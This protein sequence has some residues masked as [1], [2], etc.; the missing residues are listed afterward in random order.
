MW[1]KPSP[2]QADSCL[3]RSLGRHPS[4]P[5]EYTR[6]WQSCFKLRL[7]DTALDSNLSDRGRTSGVWIRGM[8]F[9]FPRTD[10]VN[11]KLSSLWK[12]KVWKGACSKSRCWRGYTTIV[13]CRLPLILLISG[14]LASGGRTPDLVSI[15]IRLYFLCIYV[16]LDLCMV[17]SPL[18]SPSLPPSPFLLILPICL[19]VILDF[20]L[21]DFILLYSMNNLLL[22]ILSLIISF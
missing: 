18:S 10:L 6:I 2:L 15:F 12:F 19:L 5:R 11:H 8:V 20:I 21:R 17:C 4:R 3:P 13:A 14:S 9:S 7:P 22:T 16:L 1:R